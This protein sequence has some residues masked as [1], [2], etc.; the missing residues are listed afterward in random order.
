MKR[1]LSIVLVL[2]FVMTAATPALSASAAA[3]EEIAILKKS[4]GYTY[5][6]ADNGTAYGLSEFLI[7]SGATVNIEYTLSVSELIEF[8]M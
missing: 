6:W 1:W 2:L 5:D 4:L 3:D 7:F 8:V